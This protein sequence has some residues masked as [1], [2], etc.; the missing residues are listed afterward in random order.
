MK[1]G[2]D[3]PL[4]SELADI[5][6]SMD[7]DRHVV[8]WRLVCALND[9]DWQQA[10][11]LVRM[12]GEEDD[13]AFAY[14]NAT[15]PA[16][17]YSILISRLR[18]DRPDFNSAFAHTR[19]QLNRKVQKSQGNPRLLSQLAV[20]DA[21]L[22]KKHDAI[23]VAERTIEMLPISSDAVHGPL[24]LLNLAVIYTWTDEF[25]LSFEILNTLAKA[26]GGLYFGQLKR[27]SYWEPL[28]KDPRFD[29]L[30]AEL[31]PKD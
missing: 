30:L 28:P 1:D 13:G 29:K 27:D 12:M 4:R 9:S 18:G 20:V 23:T 25:D 14:A 2:N 17:C 8:N 5:P 22:G 10:S 24:V 7:A 21:L 16:G 31:A 6:S 26:P 3:T 15:V 11:D 19:S